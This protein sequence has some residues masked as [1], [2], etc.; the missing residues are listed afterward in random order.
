LI[1]KDLINGYSGLK[2]PPYTFMEN[3]DEDV[4]ELGVADDE[5]F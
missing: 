3:E 1:S 4:D 2:E 5:W